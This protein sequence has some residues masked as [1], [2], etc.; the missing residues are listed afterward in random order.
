MSLKECLVLE[1]ERG[2]AQGERFYLEHGEKKTIGRSRICDICL[3]RLKKYKT[4]PKSEEKSPEVLG[5]SRK[6]LQITFYNSQCVE[7][8]DMSTNGT[9]MDGKKIR[10][11]IIA[12][13]KKQAHQVRLA[14]RETFKL[15]WGS[16][17]LS[18][19]SK[20]KEPKKPL[21]QSSG[22]NVTS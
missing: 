12:D 3:P 8:K 20:D 19:D 21:D 10:K 14:K 16:R 11:E 15:Y 18:A 2:L 5:I 13:I 9:Y 17:D 1:G 22:K 4:L 7:L 6:H